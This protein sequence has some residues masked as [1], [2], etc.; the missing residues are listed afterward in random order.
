MNKKVKKVELVLRKINYLFDSIE[1]N[2]LQSSNLEM[3]LLKKYAIDLYDTILE[4]EEAEAWEV[5]KTLEEMDVP[6]KEIPAENVMEIETAVETQPKVE[7]EPPLE[8]KKEKSSFFDSTVTKLGAA[9]VVATGLG[10]ANLH[11]TDE[12][13]KDEVTED[14]TNILEE[15]QRK[16]AEEDA[17]EIETEE[18]IELAEEETVLD[19]VEDTMTTEDVFQ[20]TE[21]IPEPTIED[22]STS[23]KEFFTDEELPIAETTLTEEEDALEEQ[24]RA[25]EAVDLSGLTD[26]RTTER[27]VVDMQEEEPIAFEEEEEDLIETE[28]PDSVGG[29]ETEVLTG[30]YNN[31]VAQQDIP[32]PV[33]PTVNTNFTETSNDLNNTLKQQEAKKFNIS[34]NQRFAFI[35]ELFGGDSAVYEHTLEELGKCNNVIEAFTYLNLHVKLKYQWKDDSS[36]TKE[37]QQIVKDSFLTQL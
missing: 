36:T 33:D 2:P 28:A 37:F 9:G 12:D 25:T 31:V 30:A 5:E 18:F 16:A 15:V 22:S 26:R 35:S 17:T 11:A 23:I 14:L 21:P 19:D 10:A 20:E 1:S 3:A 27:V 13:I 6:E 8:V 32:E 4:F 29:Q 24:R 34:F 7:A